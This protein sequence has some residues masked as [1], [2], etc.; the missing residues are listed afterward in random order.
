[1]RFYRLLLHL[2]PVSFRHEYGDEM[3]A[4]FAARRRD[5]GNAVARA[6]LLLSAIE[7]VAIGCVARARRHP[8]PG[9]SLCR[10]AAS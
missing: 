8:A 2:Y 5:A 7:E 3:A 6:A 10:G 1:M 9:R 4:V